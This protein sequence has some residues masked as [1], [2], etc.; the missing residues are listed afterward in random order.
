MKKALPIVS[1]LLIISLAAVG[2]GYGLWFEIMEV[3][4][5]INTGVLDV[6]WLGPIVTEYETKDVA[7]CQANIA[8]DT[9]T[10]NVSNFYPSYVCEVEFGVL[11]VG[12]IPVHIQFDQQSLLAQPPFD[13]TFL[14]CT[15]DG[16]AVPLPDPFGDYAQVHSTQNIACKIYLHADNT[17]L[18]NDTYNFEWRIISWQ[19][20]EP[21]PGSGDPPFP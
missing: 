15:Y 19:Y 14:D 20:N 4:G 21:Y 16:A 2:V 17:L 18:Q 1:L 12:S 3:R 5:T 7:T 11:N 6:E 13:G 10:I 9:L 8:A